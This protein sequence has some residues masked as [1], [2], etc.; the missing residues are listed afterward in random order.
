[1]VDSRI[2]QGAISALETLAMS[3]DEGLLKIEKGGWV[4]VA[5]KR[6]VV[7]SENKNKDSTPQSE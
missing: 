7:W 1:M 3:G 5:N 4:V 6:K 2:P